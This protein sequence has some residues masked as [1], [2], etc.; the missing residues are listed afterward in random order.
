MKL[1][2]FF[3]V[4]LSLLYCKNIQSGHI[5]LSTNQ[6]FEAKKMA[7]YME[8]K[9]KPFS[10]E[11]LKECMYYEKILHSDIVLIQSQLETG[12]Y[13]STIFK[14]N[15]NL[16]GMKYPF[17]RETSAIGI[18]YGHAFYN[19]WTDSVKD[20]KLFQEW[21]MSIGYDIGTNSDHYLVFL[22]CIR[23]ATDKLYIHKLVG[24]E[25]TDIG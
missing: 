20:Y 8:V 19:H 11:L 10:E 24:L 7:F 6:M 17:V 5:A 18:M 22:K 21:Y 13:T 25:N 16:F 14:D 4:V 2:I 9:N 15:S 12:N 3:I 23:Y 1:K